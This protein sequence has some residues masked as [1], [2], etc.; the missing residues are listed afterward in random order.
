MAKPLP[1]QYRMYLV[2]LTDE[3]VNQLFYHR[4]GELPQVIRRTPA[5]ILAGPLA[6]GEQLESGETIVTGGGVESREKNDA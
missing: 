5:G 6:V 3:E 4:Y 2:G 1:G